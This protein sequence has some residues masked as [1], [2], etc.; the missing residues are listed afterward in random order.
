MAMA[1]DT[2]DDSQVSML[3]EALRGLADDQGCVGEEALQNVPGFDESVAATLEAQL[4]CGPWHVA[5]LEE[6]FCTEPNEDLHEDQEDLPLR[7]AD[8][9]PVSLGRF[10]SPPRRRLPKRHTI[11]FAAEAQQMVD[12]EDS[13]DEWFRLSVAAEEALREE[14]ALDALHLAQLVRRM[15]E[16][17]QGWHQQKQSMQQQIDRA[18]EQ[19]KLEG[20]RAD[21]AE[22]A[23]LA[24]EAAEAAALAQVE[25]QQKRL[26]QGREA[27]KRLDQELE[28][29]R[30]RI[31]FQDADLREQQQRLKTE[32]KLRRRLEVEKQQSTTPRS[33]TPR[34]AGA[35]S[36][37]AGGVADALDSREALCKRLQAAE[38]ELEL[39]R[40]ELLA[41][42]E[43][44]QA[45]QK[46]S[47]DLE[48]ALER[49]QR[50]FV[51]LKEHLAALERRGR[52][53]REEASKSKS[54]VDL[55]A[56]LGQELQTLSSGDAAAG[57]KATVEPSVTVFDR[58]ARLQ[59]QLSR[60]S[61]NKHQIVEKPSAKT[62]TGSG[63]LSRTKSSMPSD[64]A[65]LSR[66]LG[67]GLLG[68][69]SR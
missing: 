53:K 27:I 19:A 33:A 55:G 58:K 26:I 44:A 46:R 11:S 15:W 49:S 60:P 22:T 39:L 37:G 25:E 16:M 13:D 36:S 65:S 18:V 32:E 31:D 6:L 28:E 45:E 12:G 17:M 10:A 30:H 7:K 61:A 34:A 43:A 67:G 23:R 40:E 62:G 64:M 2:M 8:V 54:C 59:A 42:E 57:P 3:R 63:G 69:V 38:A 1:M 35:T 24:A 66:L 50:D 51:E 29:A 4:G 56:S 21:H 9:S 14:E 68:E 20:D 5:T 47:V 52:R 48:V 41:S